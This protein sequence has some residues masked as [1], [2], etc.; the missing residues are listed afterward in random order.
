[1]RIAKIPDNFKTVIKSAA[2]KLSGSK[3]REYIA[4]IT[5]ELLEGNARKAEREFGWGRETVKKAMRELDTGIICLD[6]YSARGNKKTEEKM[7]GLV[8][9]IRSIIELNSSSYKST[10]PKAVRQSLILMKGYRDE[11]LP[12]ETTIENI[13]NRTAPP[14]IQTVMFDEL[15]V[16]CRKE[17][18]KWLKENGE[19][20]GPEDYV[21][22]ASKEPIGKS[23]RRIWTLKFV[24]ADEF[25]SSD[26]LLEN[27]DDKYYKVVDY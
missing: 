4:E 7:P 22:L 18:R 16:R 21:I 6:N 26:A 8:E 20:L 12:S 9:D 1:M 10:T 15:P 17:Y 23:G 5:Y 2:N 3:R 25:E 14:S 27:H 11:Q 24:S 19:D 13:I